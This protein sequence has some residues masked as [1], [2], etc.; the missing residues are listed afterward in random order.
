[1]ANY[2]LLHF[3]KHNINA[4]AMRDYDDPFAFYMMFMH[5][6]EIG[7]YNDI[8]AD[9]YEMHRLLHK[10]RKSSMA[11]NPDSAKQ[12]IQM[13]H[14]YEYERYEVLPLR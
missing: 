8:D 3:D 1:M 13:R 12:L 14:D 5:I 11:R 6:D 7:Y 4:Y 9:D 10:A 2:V